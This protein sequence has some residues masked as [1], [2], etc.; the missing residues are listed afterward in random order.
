MLR[1][2]HEGG[3]RTLVATPHMF[4]PLFDNLDPDLVRLSFER[5]TGH[6]SELADHHGL[7]F[8]SELTLHLGA[9]H[10]VSVEFLEALAE[11]RVLTLNDTSYLLIKFPPLFS[12]DMAISAVERVLGAGYV[13]VL[14]HVERYGFV[15]RKPSH[16]AGFR[17]LGCVCQLNADSLS[18]VEGRVAS[19][20]AGRRAS[21]LAWS[22]VERGLVQ[23]IASDG[24]DPSDRPPDLGRAFEAL[25]REGINP[26][27]ASWLWENPQQIMAGKRLAPAVPAGG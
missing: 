12:L 27:T 16:L 21:R 2:A 23:L 6:L 7:E 14:A 8:L 26:T 19:R 3:T 4:M 18:P 11:H 20:G 5:L 13:P 9:E 10:Y 22:L 24:H 1:R 15:Q 17:K 25:E